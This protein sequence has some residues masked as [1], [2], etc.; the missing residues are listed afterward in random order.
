[1]LY[2]H[3]RVQGSTVYLPVGSF[4]DHAGLPVILDTLLALYASCSA[5]TLCGGLV[6]WPI[7]YGYSPMHSWSVSLKP[8]LLRELVSAVASG[9]LAAGALRVVVV[10]G[11]YGHRSAVADA[12]RSAGA[13]YVNVWSL[14]EEE[15]LTSFEEMLE[16]ER[17]FSAVL[18]GRDSGRAAEVLDAVARRLCSLLG[19]V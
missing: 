8:A 17:E 11:H 1:M 4:E 10:D 19:S 16:F 2:S 7:G 18:G 3:K 6:A 9:L 12:A 5:S 13:L 15:G 14:L